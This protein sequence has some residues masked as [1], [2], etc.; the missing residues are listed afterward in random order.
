MN[1]LSQSSG[2]TL[3]GAFALIMVLSSVFLRK[4]HKSVDSFL[5]ANRKLNWMSGGVSIAASW[6]WAP[7]LFVSVQVAYEKGLAGLFW[8]TVPN[9]AALLLFAI[10]GPRIRKLFPEG[11]SL[12]QFIKQRFKSERLHKLH[13]FPYFFYQL[14][15]VTV[16]LFAGGSLMSLLTGIPLLTVMPLLLI[17][18]LAYT[19]ISGLRATVLT[20]VIQLIMIFGIGALILPMAWKAGGSWASIVGG[21]NGI[22]QVSGVFDPGVAF[23]FGVV[24]AIGLIAGAVSDQQYWQRSFAIEEKHLGK[25]FLL[26]GLLF[27]LV[28]LGLSVLGFLAVNPELGITLPEGVDASM[29]GVQTVVTLLPA[30]SAVLF[31][32]MLLAGLSSTLD[33][34][35]SAVS[36]LW[37][38][39]VAKESSVKSARYAMVGIGV[40]GLLVAYAANAIPSFGLQHLWWIFN[41]IAACTL[42]PTLMSLYS[43]KL[44]EK[45]V[46]W[47]VLIA[48][49]LG[50]P[51]F[52]YSNILGDP[53]WI[54]GSAL[55]V[56]G[57]SG[58]ASFNLQTTK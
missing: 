21:F 12:P 45:R 16:Q 36:V 38:V 41:T 49:V 37:A 32:I 4:K 15:A 1:I 30:W 24:T 50:V 27:A 3:L 55:F 5:L 8:F 10:L 47:G 6:I 34:A 23:S 40:L 51:L 57:V 22:E 7:A 39:D 29:I 11:A 58:L 2:L 54:V 33:S 25:S 28:P 56:V 44:S 42:V 14:M 20:D 52:I 17:I 48:F 18:A 35:L 9:V 26:G 53:V 43:N 13:L 19:L 31:V 46:F